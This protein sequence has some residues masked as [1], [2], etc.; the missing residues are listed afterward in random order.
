MS[1][2]GIHECMYMDKDITIQKFQGDW[3]MFVP[4]E[5][6]PEADD[7]WIWIKYCP[8]CGEQLEH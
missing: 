6:E 5:E 8:F 4:N 2:Y 1:T 3:Y 7:R